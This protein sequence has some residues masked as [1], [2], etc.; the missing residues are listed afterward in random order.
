MRRDCRLWEARKD[1]MRFILTSEHFG[2]TCILQFYILPVCESTISMIHVQ[3][4]RRCSIMYRC[5]E[6]LSLIH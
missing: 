3:L 4:F 2:R 1:P 5:Q 6:A